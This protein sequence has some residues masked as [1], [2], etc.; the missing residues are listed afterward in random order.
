MFL[1]KCS[2]RNILSH[3]SA[4]DNKRYETTRSSEKITF[5]YVFSRISN[6]LLSTTVEKFRIKKQIV[7]TN[8]K[9]GICLAQK[10]FK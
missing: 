5:F 2:C 8:S 9:T 3:Y 10:F 1:K 7:A 6:T 4:I